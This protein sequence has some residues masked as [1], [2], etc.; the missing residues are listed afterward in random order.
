[1]KTEN[2]WCVIATNLDPAFAVMGNTEFSYCFKTRKA[3]RKFKRD[4]ASGLIDGYGPE[5]EKYEIF[6]VTKTQ[7]KNGLLITGHKVR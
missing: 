4:M 2:S 7:T 5:G 6:R 1:M 3:A